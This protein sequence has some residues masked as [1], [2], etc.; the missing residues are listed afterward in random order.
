MAQTS[1][2]T[3]RV[4]T[5]KAFGK[6]PIQVP[7][8]L[9]QHPKS[10]SCPSSALMACAWRPHSLLVYCWDF[11]RM[12]PQGIKKLGQGNTFL[13]AAGA[14]SAAC[15]MNRPRL[16]C[17]TFATAPRGG[18]AHCR[19]TRIPLLANGASQP[20][21]GPGTPPDCRPPCA[22]WEP[23][24]HIL[25]LHHA[26]RRYSNRRLR[27]ASKQAPKWE[28]KSGINRGPHN[29]GGAH[30]AGGILLQLPGHPAG[31]RG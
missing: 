9:D 25:S 28:G 3:L 1:G 10:C 31:A 5:P 29:A 15:G 30:L 21:Q 6:R 18:D 12:L 14:N 23:R 22:G 11:H 27:A 20:A 16:P 24:K 17:C 2:N 19:R 13:S 4:Q 26:T 8:V 7:G